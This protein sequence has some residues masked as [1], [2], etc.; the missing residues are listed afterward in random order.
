[1]RFVVIDRCPVPAPLAEEINAIKAK[2]GATLVSCDRS[3]EAEPLLRKHGKKSQR[4]LYACFVNFQRTG[5]C[6]CE[7]CNPANPPGRSTHERRNDGVAYPGPAGAPLR[8]WQAGMDWSNARG[9]VEAAK[10]LGFT[11]T[12]TYP[13]NPREQH[14]VNF[15]REPIIVVIPTLKRGGKGRRVARLRRDLYFI[16]SVHDGER[17]FSTHEGST[18]TR[19][20]EAAV[21]RLQREHHQKADGIVGVQTRR[22]IA[23]LVRQEKKRRERDPKWWEKV[24]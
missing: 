9:V 5:R 7:S 21:K 3:P 10:R 24:R 11:A 22:Q 1:M 2:T 23:T 19:E 13:H 14:H 8:Y 4:Q 20:L 18:F 16:H 17:Y 15:R 6:A 12:V